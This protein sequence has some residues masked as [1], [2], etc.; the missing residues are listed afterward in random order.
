MKSKRYWFNDEAFSRLCDIVASD[1]LVCL[2]GAGISS[3]LRH[4]N[5]RE[6]G[7][8]QWGELLN[9]LRNEFSDTLAK[10]DKMDV[11]RLLHK[12]ASSDELIQAA[13][14]LSRGREEGFDKRI[15]EAVTHEPE[16]TTRTHEALLK[17]YPRGILTF[18]YDL[19]HENAI[20][21]RRPKEK[22]ETFL[23]WHEEPFRQALEEGIP[24]PFLLKAHGSL[25]SPAPLV[26]TFQS[27]RNLLEKCPV[28]RAFVHNLLINFNFLIVG[29]GLS[30]P[31]FDQ[32]I[33]E[34]SFQ[35]GAPLRTHV[36][37]RHQKVKKQEVLLRQRYGIHTLY[38]KEFDDIPLVIT[39]AIHTTGPVLNKTI[40]KCLATGKEGYDA[41]VEGHEELKRLGR[42]GKI[43]AS[44]VL[45]ARIKTTKD[46][47]S[48]FSELAYSLGKLDPK[49]ESTNQALCKIVEESDY[50]EPVAHALLALQGALKVKDLDWLAGQLERVK[51]GR[52]KFDNVEP[53]P[54]NRLPIYLEFLIHYVRA[55]HLDFSTP[56]RELIKSRVAAKGT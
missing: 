6:K 48:V 24:R 55:K 42:A 20:E 47:L 39:D 26:L 19:A 51:R 33:E 31:D 43:H 22:W 34:L 17:I 46:N 15:R 45:R 29:F 54:D 9:T 37:I 36:V 41:R 44:N 13:T 28:Y 56:L 23:P 4:I 18:N 40:E 32:F 7:L 25:D 52:L 49:E 12:K 3:P 5:D 2:T 50:V 8:P 38:V 14:I 11:R 35:M 53:D 10:N 1:K 21:R 16:A 30:D 27:Y